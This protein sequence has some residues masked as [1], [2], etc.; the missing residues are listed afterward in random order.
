MTGSGWLKVMH[1]RP[2]GKGSKTEKMRKKGKLAQMGGG[3]RICGKTTGHSKS[4][5]GRTKTAALGV[6]RKAVVKEQ[7]G[8]TEGSKRGKKDAAPD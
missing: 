1:R 2:E 7:A 8:V 5:A 6:G 3:D 4:N